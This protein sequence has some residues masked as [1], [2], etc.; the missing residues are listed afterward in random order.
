MDTRGRNSTALTGVSAEVSATAILESITDG[1]H[2]V[3]AAGR[4]MQFN[5][6]AREMFQAQGLDPDAL[7][8]RD[9][10]S[11]F[12]DLQENAAGRGLLSVLRTGK[13]AAVE[14]YYAPWG[15]WFYVRHY[16]TPDGGVASLF[17]DITDIKRS[18]GLLREQR[19]RFTFATDAAQ[20]GYWFCDLPFDKLIWDARV[21]EHF[22]IAPEVE[23]DID[24]FYARLHPEDRE[25]IRQAIR[26][27]IAEHARYDVEYRT[28]SPKGEQKWVRAIGRTAYDETGVPLR[29][30][31]VTQ[32]ITAL[33]QAKA[34]LRRSEDRFEVFANSIPALAWMADPEGRI[35]WYNKRWYDYTGT[36]QSD[37]ED[38]GWESVH[39]PA[40]LPTVL[41]R[42]KACLATGESFEM[43]FPL[44]GADGVFRHFLTRM[45]P[46]RNEYGDIVYWFGTNTDVDEQRKNR[47]ALDAERRRL[48]AVFENA[49]I[50]L[51]FADADGKIVSGN[52]RAEQMFGHPVLYSPNIDSYREWVAFHPDGRRVEGREFPLAR[53]LSDGGTHTGEYIYQR[54]DGTNIWVEFT[55]APIRNEAGDILGGV[56]ATADIDARKRAE[57]ALVRNEKLVL[58]GRLAATISHEINN[59]LESV[60]NLLYLLEETATDDTARTY[61]RTALRELARVSHI[62][63][64][65]LRY[66]RQTTERSWEKLS[67]LMDSALAIYEARIRNS[68]IALE[69]R[70]TERDEVLC[71]GSEVRQVFAN[72]AGNAFDATRRGGRIVVRIRPQKH[73]RNRAPG[74]RVTLADTGQGMDPRTARRLFEPFF[75]TKGDNG[76]GLGLWVSREI[77][78]KHEATIRVRS[79]QAPGRSGTAFSIWFPVSKSDRQSGSIGGISA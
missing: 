58:V 57:Q 51:V 8:G 32:D 28:V 18:E 5:P 16:S 67:V 22:W 17:Q 50:G 40:V 68:G 75:T 43:T 3:D 64:H 69:R 47:L 1:F 6:A 45:A 53:A 42:W 63:T 60:T 79:S 13:P 59:P 30:D 14:N 62:V 4:F 71:L 46:V 65:T 24:L 66:N 52:R 44:R 70:F 10:R 77:L 73:W 25:R 39:D 15:R 36:T 37:M 74:V 7:I 78:D 27:S 38:D 26:S 20:I 72:L 29:F 76:T 35:F 12:P 49:P 21:K 61:A 48:A 34:A 11:V 55:G 19:E 41:G 2:L 23:V 31:G 56:V 33:K 9:I 54:G